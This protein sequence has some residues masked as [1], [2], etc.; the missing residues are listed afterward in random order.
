MFPPFGRSPLRIDLSSA[1]IAERKINVKRE[2][3]LEKKLGKL[4]R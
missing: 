3:D 4:H 1:S 2:A